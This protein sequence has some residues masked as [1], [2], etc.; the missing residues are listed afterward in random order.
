MVLGLRFTFVFVLDSCVLPWALLLHWESVP[1]AALVGEAQPVLDP[2]YIPTTAF[3]ATNGA[4]M[5]ICSDGHRYCIFRQHLL[6]TV[7][8][9]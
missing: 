5:L 1:T 7:M 3:L 8:S 4:A 6:I 9:R 2:T